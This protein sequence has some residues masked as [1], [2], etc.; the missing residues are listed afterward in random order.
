MGRFRADGLA[1]T[2]ADRLDS[3]KGGEKAA[4]ARAAH[5][6]KHRIAVA[7]FF[8]EEAEIPGRAEAADGRR[9]LISPSAARAK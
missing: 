8:I 5:A 9:E 4:L 6:A 1:E 2:V 7:R 3:A